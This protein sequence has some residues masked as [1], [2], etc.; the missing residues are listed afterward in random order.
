MGEFALKTKT[1]G[2]EDQRWVGNGGEPGLSPRSIVLDRQLFN[3]TTGYPNGF[4]PSGVKL[5]KVTATGLYGPYGGASERSDEAQTVTVGGSGLTSFTLTFADQTTAAI[6]A[7][8]TAVQVDAALE[9]L[10][11][12]GAGDVVVT[13]ANGGPWTVTFAGA[14]ADTDVAQMTATPTGGTGTVTVAT[15]V[16]G[17]VEGASDGREVL[18][19]HLF[20][21]EAY[22][23][24]SV[25]DIPAALF[26]DGVVVE[27]FLPDGPVDTAGKADVAGHIKYVTDVVGKGN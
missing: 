19:G 6:A 27:T 14:L 9:A 2:N 8:A 24:D 16:P 13:G 17:G 20:A 5:G 7:A 12:I 1:Y 18:S 11:N 3:L 15:T 22:D 23:R 26:W 25:G 10:S 4:I 21:T